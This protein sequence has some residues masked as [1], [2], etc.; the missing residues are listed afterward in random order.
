MVILRMRSH[1]EV[2]FNHTVDKDSK[3]LNRY[4]GDLHIPEGIRIV[5]IIREDGNETVKIYP[6]MDTRICEGDRIVVFTNLTKESDLARVF[7]KNVA[8]EL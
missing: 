2:F 8:V 6:R 4:Y 7:G 1:N 5:A 3:L